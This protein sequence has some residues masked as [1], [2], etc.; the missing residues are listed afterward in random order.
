MP[1]PWPFHHFKFEPGRK[2][3]LQCKTFILQF[4]LIQPALGFLTFVLSITDNYHEGSFS[5]RYGYLYI[6]I[7]DNVSISFCLYYL[8]L[9]WISLDEELKPFNPVGK[10]L[11]IK[12]MPSF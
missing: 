1:H 3:Y 6:T 8:V 2:F 11:C 12:V 7:L 4:V 9:F 10:F 5:P